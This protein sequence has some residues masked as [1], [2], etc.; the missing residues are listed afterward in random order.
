MKKGYGL[1]A[2][3]AAFVLML[4]APIPTD[5]L[6]EAARITAAI[7]L[8]MVIFWITQPIPIEATSL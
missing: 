4:I 7:T 3:L 1:I 6:P 2:G 8:M 5:V